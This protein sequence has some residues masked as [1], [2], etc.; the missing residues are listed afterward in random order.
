MQLVI[1]SGLSEKAA[2][3]ESYLFHFQYHSDIV[4]GVALAQARG[5]FAVNRVHKSFSAAIKSLLR[6]MQGMDTLASTLQRIS[7]PSL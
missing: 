7:L 2:V 6:A 3:L 5:E 1:T 4:S